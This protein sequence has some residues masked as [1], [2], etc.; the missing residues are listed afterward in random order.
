M[1]ELTLEFPIFLENESEMEALGA[2]I[3]VSIKPG[4]IIFL[5]GDLGAGKTTFVRGFLRG[6]GHQGNVKSPTYT[7]VE[8]YY[9][10]H[11]WVYHFDLYRIVDAEE[12]EWMGMREYFRSDAILLIEWPEKGLGFLPVPDLSLRIEILAVGRQV[13]C[14]S[15]D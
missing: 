4:S 8:E 14:L 15:T 13:S 3:A 5:E 12:L 7:L 2:S 6:L 9:L 11:A 10:N 1:S